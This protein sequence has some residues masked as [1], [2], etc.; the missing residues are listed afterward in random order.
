MR[1]TVILGFVLFVV[2]AAG[3]QVPIINKVEPLAGAPQ[4]TIL[5]TGSGFSRTITDLQGWFDHVKCTIVPPC[6]KFSIQVQIP[7]QAR[8]SNVEV[9]NLVTG[10]SRSPQ[11]KFMLSYGG[12]S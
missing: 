10:L 4:Q 7:A 1:T 11:L 8:L 9:I 2:T 6:T 5:I 12:S 3:A